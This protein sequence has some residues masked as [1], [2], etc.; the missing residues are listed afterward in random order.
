MPIRGLIDH[1][2]LTVTDYGKSVPFYDRV[3]R[4]L[5]FTRLEGNPTPVWFM[6]Y[7]SGALW[8]IALQLVRPASRDKDHDRYA[9]GLHHIAFH[10]ESRA[11]VD[12]TYAML[13]EIG[14]RVLDPPAEYCGQEYAP[15]YSAV[16]FADPDG[17]KLEVVH[18]PCGNANADAG[19]GT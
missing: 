18:Q 13:R 12:A 5:G 10:A 19:S 16:F 17:V 14:A 15:G 8:G 7:P 3:L 6:R 2:D 11:D 4:H 1:I 9:P